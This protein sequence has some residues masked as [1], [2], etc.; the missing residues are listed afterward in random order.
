MKEGQEKIYFL[1][2][3]QFELAEK[4][5]Y[6][7][8]FKNSEIDVLILTN[9]VDEIL[10]Q[11]IGEFKGK[12]FVSI[13]S[14]FDEIQKDLGFDSEVESAERSR[15]PENDL[16]PFLLW[17]KEEL[18]DNIGKVTISKRLKDTPAI[19]TGNMSSSMRIMM[20][21][22]E[23]HGQA[24]P[25]MLQ[26][27][28]KEQVLELNAAHPIVVNLNQL[29]KTNK[30]AAKLVANQFLD[31]VLVQSG[32]PFDLQAGTERQFQLL[33]SYLELVVNVQDAGASRATQDEAEVIIE[34]ES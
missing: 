4:S 24:D 19:I 31:N 13:E 11:Q 25:Q 20:Q 21:M 14:N 1:V 32:I 26:K 23:S 10:F 27:A 2:N 30:P 22:M 5:P 33:A 6:M 16:T 29:R 18:K 28:T 12:R 3:N 9:N 15:L 8:P 34:A 7:E 17:L